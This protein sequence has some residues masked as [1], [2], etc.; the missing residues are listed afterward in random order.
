MAAGES[1]SYRVDATPKVKQQIQEL[2]K[3]AK[4]RGMV[5]NYV[6]A[7]RKLVDALEQAPL[8]WGDPQ[9]RTQQ[10]GGLVCQGISNPLLVHYAV[11]EQ[12]K[13]VLIIDLDFLPWFKEDQQSS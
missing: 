4:H 9:Y 10:Q 12:E 8:D 1:G 11:Y 6:S 7:L 5:G 2:R 3:L 13:S